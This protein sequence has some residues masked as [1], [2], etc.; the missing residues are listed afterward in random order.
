MIDTTL[1]IGSE[2]QLGS[3]LTLALNA[4]KGQGNV[5]CSDIL[6]SSKH[7][8]KY[9]KLNVL[10]QP[11][12]RKALEKYKITT[13]YHLAAVLSAKG[14]SNPEMAWEVNMKGLLH[15]L[16]LGARL[17]INKIFWPSSIAIFGPGTQS[18]MTPQ[19]DYFDPTSV[20]G[21][22]K[23]AGELWCKYFYD[24]YRVDVRSL[25]YPGVISYKAPPG[26]GTTDYAI[27]IF[28]E[29]LKSGNYECF[30]DKNMS[31]PMIYVDDAI[32]A[33]LE[34]MD[35]PAKSITVRTSYNLAAVSFTPK[36]IAGAVKKRIPNF[37]ISYK[38]DFRN[39]IAASWPDS[40]DD[41]LARKDWNWE[42]EYSIDRMVDEM[43]AGLS[44]S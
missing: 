7:P 25:R 17:K 34:L 5:I 32:R 16:D 8:N 4:K 10:N 28:I 43:L 3:E 27:E 35:A 41:S 20:Y 19:N 9:L 37:K 29:A 12:L 44:K 30:L 26:G 1:I 38:L 21:I 13:V 15:I 36:E 31:L 2:G 33:T 14:E 22:S 39:E 40:I 23:L 24:K 11:E 42:H 6:D 18:E